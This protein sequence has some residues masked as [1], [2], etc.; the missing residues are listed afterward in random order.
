MTVLEPYR[1][2]VDT[3]LGHRHDNGSDFWCTPEGGIAVG[4]PFST[5]ESALMLTELGMSPS[6]PE[7]RGA[8]ERIWAAAR[9]DGRLPVTPKGA[10]YPCHTTG[11]ARILCRLGYAS[12]PRLARTYD[13]LLATQ[14][15]DGGWRCNTYKYGR[16]P[17]T[18]ASNPGPTLHALDVFRHTPKA[19]RDHRLDAAVRFLLGHWDT[20]APMGP[21][22]FGIGSRF[23]RV[24]FPFFRYNL[25][26]YVYVLSF[27]RAAH[28]DP[29]FKAAVAALESKVVH[30]E[31]VLEYAR[32][33]LRGLRLCEPGKPNALATRRYHELLANLGRRAG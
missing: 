7:L 12:D 9:E 33:D 1:G 25:F 13:H 16:G 18:A 2:D 28:A 32:P 5:L 8:A 20:R 3:I 15:P 26:A 4:S 19:N 31:V 6:R 27:Y 11:V 10:I 17:E 29:R 22:H 21:C 30:G 14:E 23:L 24:E